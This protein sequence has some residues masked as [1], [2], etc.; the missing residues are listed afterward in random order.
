MI[1]TYI[2]KSQKFDRI[3]IGLS[4][5]P[6]RRL[7]EHNSGQ[8]RSTK[9]YLPFNIIVREAH[10]NLAEARARE[11]KLKQGEMR[12]VFKSNAG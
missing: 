12:E 8:V 6:D 1:Y 7:R 9:K 10:P 5:D 4:N 11:K 3:Y 2:L